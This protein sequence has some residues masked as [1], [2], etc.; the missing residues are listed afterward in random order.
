MN[1]LGTLLDQVDQIT[2]DFTF[3][4]YAALVSHMTPAIVLAITVY[5]ALMGWWMLQGWSALSISELTKHV[6]KIAI[7][8]TL[9]TQWDVFSRFIYE[10]LT[11]GP[12]EISAVLMRAT[13]SSS[14]GVNA[15]LEQAFNSGMQVGET[16]WNLSGW[17]S[18]LTALMIWL[19]NYG[20][21]GVALFELVAAKLGLSITLVLAPLFF[22]FALWQATQG[23]FTSWLRFA[24]G[25]ALAP[26]F[27]SS[28]LLAIH[29]L[30]QLSAEQV[31]ADLHSPSANLMSVTPLVLSAIVS[32][33]V[34]FKAADIAANIAGGVS[35]SGIAI[36]ARAATAADRYSGFAALRRRLAQRRGK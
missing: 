7:V 6:L 20:V 11:N 30:M 24:L 2:Q 21:V 31:Q 1:T 29:Q 26:L 3:N 32:I 27:L 16:L 12:N 18:K 19:L 17:S 36:A 9:A 10:V 33:G 23:M 25:F 22:L 15:A 34:L 35:I 13:G 4:G 5:I 28:V 14:E 8:F